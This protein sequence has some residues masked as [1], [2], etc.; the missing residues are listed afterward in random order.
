MAIAAPATK[1]KTRGIERI[2][3]GQRGGLRHQGFQNSQEPLTEEPP[4]GS[5]N[6]P[7]DQPLDQHLS[8]QASLSGTEGGPHDELVASGRGTRQRHARD[9]GAGNQQQYGGG[10]KQHRKVT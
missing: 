5:G 1:A 6:E 8:H 9:V 7:E 3:R 4:D 10:A 2:D